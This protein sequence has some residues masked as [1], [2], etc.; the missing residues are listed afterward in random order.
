MEVNKKTQVVM[1]PTDDLTNIALNTSEDIGLKYFTHEGGDAT[2]TIWINQ[3]LYFLSDEEIKEGD[4]YL[5]E[6]FDI[7]KEGIGLHLER[8]CSIDHEWVNN[9]LA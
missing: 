2:K 5:V 6:L 3:R 4:Y 9:K 8:A 7:K 1:L